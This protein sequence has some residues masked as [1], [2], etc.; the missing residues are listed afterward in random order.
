M[1]LHTILWMM[2]YTS[3]GFSQQNDTHLVVFRKI[4]VFCSCYTWGELKAGNCLW[5]W[6]EEWALDSVCLGSNPASWL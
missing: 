4:T 5:D 3:Q 6:L 1:L 2:R